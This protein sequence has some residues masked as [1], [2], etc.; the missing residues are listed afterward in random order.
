MCI[1]TER[2]AISLCAGYKAFPGDVIG[3]T[4]K[5]EEAQNGKVPVVFNVNGR[6]I[7]LKDTSGM[8]CEEWVECS[9]TRDLFP[10]IGIDKRGKGMRV[11]AKVNLFPLHNANSLIWTNVL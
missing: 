2:I 4:V 7:T 9:H 10:Y 11:M 5:F 1:F 3:C 8:T 6:V